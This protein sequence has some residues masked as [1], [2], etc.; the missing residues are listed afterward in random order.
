MTVH[1][2][3]DDKARAAQADNRVITAP[4]INWQEQKLTFNRKF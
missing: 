3:L 1:A 4:L 2:S